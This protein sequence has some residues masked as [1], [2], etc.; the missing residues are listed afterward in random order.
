MS[1]SQHI[2]DKEEQ[3]DTSKVGDTISRIDAPK[4]DQIL[5]DF[6]SFKSYLHKRIALG[7]SLGLSEEQLAQVAEKVADYLAGHE[8]PRNA[9]ENLL[10]ELWKVGEQDERHKLAHMLVRLA[11]QA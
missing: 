7:E 3:I 11:Q 5:N 4:K 10:R 9:E 1:E 6:E 8:D 2:I